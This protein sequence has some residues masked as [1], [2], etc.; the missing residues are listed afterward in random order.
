VSLSDQL[1]VE[2]GGVVVANVD[3]QSVAVYGTLSG[4]VVVRDLITLH[5]GCAVTANLRAPRIVIEEGARFKGN[6]D[7]DVSNA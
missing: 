7:M 1:R 5:A 2:A 4:E 6:I 3:A